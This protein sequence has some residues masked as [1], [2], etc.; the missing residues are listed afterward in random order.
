MNK[1]ILRFVICALLAGALPSARA[2][3]VL[4]TWSEQIVIREGWLAK[5][6][7]M[8]LPMMRRHGINM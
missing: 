8:L 7:A 1:T 4:P 3:T 2:Q 6:H 5:R